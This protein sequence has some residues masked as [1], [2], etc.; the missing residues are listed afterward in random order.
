[1]RALILDVSKQTDASDTI[2]FEVKP[3]PF[4]Y[5]L[6]ASRALIVA[7]F[8]LSVFLVAALMIIKGGPLLFLL[9]VV[10]LLD[11]I[12]VSVFFLAVLLIACSLS[13]VL[14]D[15]N[16]VVRAA[17]ARLC[18]PLDE[19][20]SVSVRSYGAEYGSVYLE[21]YRDALEKVSC[22]SVNLRPQ[23]GSI[24]LSMPRSRP[25]LMGFLGFRDFSKFAS[26]IVDLRNAVQSSHS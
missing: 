1:M 15:R 25:Q 24:W 12:F 16:V 6:E 9:K 4:L 17:R 22:K 3:N 18:V 13:F 11:F 19:I 5:A 20:K 23:S 2:L 21:R 10:S 8:A 14:T 7:L 26:M